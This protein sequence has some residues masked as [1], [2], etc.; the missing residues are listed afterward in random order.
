MFSSFKEHG[1]WTKK[2]KSERLWKGG[3]WR[4]GEEEGR[5][6]GIPSVILGAT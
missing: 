3:E 1:D 5:K 4:R 2:A 6:E